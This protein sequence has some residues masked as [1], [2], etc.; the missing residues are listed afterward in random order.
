M[1]SNENCCE[2]VKSLFRVKT[3]HSQLVLAFP[4]LLSPG[5]IQPDSNEIFIN[6]SQLL[7]GDIQPDSDEIT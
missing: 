6:L 3:G 2:F 7:P 1:L 5:D 4:L